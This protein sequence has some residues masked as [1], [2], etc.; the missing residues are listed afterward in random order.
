MIFSL[1]NTVFTC[2]QHSSR[3]RSSRRKANSCAGYPY[4]AQDF[5]HIS[6]SSNPPRCAETQ[7]LYSK[8][9]KQEELYK[10]VAAAPSWDG[11]GNHARHGGGGSPLDETSAEAGMAAMS[12]MFRE[13]GGEVYLPATE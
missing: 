2:K 8:S 10:F 11:E 4:H 7:T 9:R 1:A 13:K 12:E 3:Q 5:H 6:S